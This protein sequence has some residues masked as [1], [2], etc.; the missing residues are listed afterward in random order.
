[1]IT[2]FKYLFMPWTR[3]LCV[4]SK[5]SRDGLTKFIKENSAISDVGIIGK[6]LNMNVEYISIQPFERNLEIKVFM[7]IHMLLENDFKK[8]GNT[9]FMNLKVIDAVQSTHCSNRGQEKSKS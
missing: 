5:I 4:E 1:M 3:I 8:Q 2:L 6:C 7:L 9:L